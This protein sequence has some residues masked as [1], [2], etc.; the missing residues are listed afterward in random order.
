MAVAAPFMPFIM[1]AGTAFSAISQYQAGKYQAAVASKNAEIMDKRA[2]DENFAMAEDMQG[3]DQEASAQI[4]E[5]VAE[6]AASGVD[7]N[8]GTALLRRRSLQNLASRDRS[9]LARQKETQLLNNKQSAA[10]LRAEAA[11]AKQG[12][13][14][15]LVGGLLETPASYLSGA[16]M[17]ND[18]QYN[19]GSMI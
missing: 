14:M 8:S 1:A 12:A 19:R 3:R 18:Y 11:A 9:R 16:K 15:S 6:Q 4:A 5:L 2:S 13:T 7:I 17:Y 10:G